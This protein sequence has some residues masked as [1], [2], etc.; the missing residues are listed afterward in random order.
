MNCSTQWYQAWQYDSW[1]T[2]GIESTP[3][4]GES[5]ITF[6]EAPDD[7]WISEFNAGNDLEIDSFFGGSWFAL[8]TC[9]QWLRR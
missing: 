8:I 1:L 5:A 9:E 4:G 7:N 6:V 2:I 3:Q